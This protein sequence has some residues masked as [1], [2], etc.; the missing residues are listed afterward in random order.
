MVL[1]YHGFKILES[2]LFVTYRN[3]V[4]KNKYFS[5]SE[6]EL[7]L[8]EFSKIKKWKKSPKN[9]TVIRDRETSELK[10]VYNSLVDSESQV[11][12]KIIEKVNDG[13]VLTYFDISYDGVIN[14]KDAS[15]F[16]L[17]IPK[18]P[19]LNSDK[20][21]ENLEYARSVIKNKIV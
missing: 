6:V 20:V 13:D 19:G 17:K 9:Y 4:S 5:D 8:N 2:G 7:L 12:G 3:V 11:E 16:P 15:A 1:E 14:N 21:I 18:Y 10:V